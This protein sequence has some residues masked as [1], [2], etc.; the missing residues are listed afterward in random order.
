MRPSWLF[1]RKRSYDI[2]AHVARVKK[3]HAAYPLIARKDCDQH[4]L[5]LLKRI[6]RIPLRLIIP[7]RDAIDHLYIQSEY[8]LTYERIIENPHSLERLEKLLSP[9]RISAAD[10][11]IVA[12]FDDF[13]RHVP[14]EADTDPDVPSPVVP[15]I[16]AFRDPYVVMQACIRLA[17]PHFPFLGHILSRNVIRASGH[18]PLNYKGQRLKALEEHGS[19]TDALELVLGD[20]PL[21]RLFAALIPFEIPEATWKEHGFLFAKSGHGKTQTLRSITTSLLEKDCALFLIDG[22]GSLIEHVDR[23]ES[24]QDRLVVIDCAAEE[25]PNLNLFKL[26]SD[27]LYFYLFK[28]IDQSFTQRQA[29]MI[30]Y[31]MELVG[32]LPNPTLRSLIELCE[33]RDIDQYHDIVGT[34]SPFAQSFFSNQF[35]GKKVDQLVQQTKNQIAARL[36]TLGRLPKFDQMLSAPS[37]DFDAF[38]FMQEKKIVV[39]NTDARSPKH[40]GLGEA[41]GIIGRFMLAQILDAA[42]ARPKD[43]RHLALI[44]LDEAKHYL[45]DHTSLI[46]SDARQYGLGLLLATQFPDQLEDGVRKEVINNTSVK[47]CGPAAYSVVA[48]V[49]RDMRCE[50][51]FILSMKKYD[52]EYAEWACYVDNLTSQAIRLIV[53]FGAIE[54]LPF[55]EVSHRT[56]RPAAPRPGPMRPTLP[57]QPQAKQHS[58][59]PSD[60]KSPDDSD[61]DRWS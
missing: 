13:L 12:F 39:I 47:M 20:T 43:Q 52:R 31:L 19:P 10:D 54:R 21:F 14:P 26:G 2:K 36:Y 56:G 50:A 33:T 46:L 15:L 49:Q 24:I 23:I 60:A 42:R 34:L 28:A 44:I 1:P 30:S 18:D 55:V 16:D 22:L 6:K 5:K 4:T 27:D 61:R 32:K 45:D 11:A 25:P 41:S 51:D 48:Q 9:E 57:I 59:E 53:P 29:T 58:A 3:L 8:F 7:I 40:G 37:N 17:D 35:F 38:R